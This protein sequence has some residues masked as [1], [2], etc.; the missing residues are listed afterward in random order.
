MKR[1]PKCNRTYADDAFTFCL[2][3]GA[4]LSAPYDPEKKEEPIST[5]QSGGPPPTAVLPAD[6]GRAETE[7]NRAAFPTIASPAVSAD[8]PEVKQF[9]PPEFQA[10]AAVSKKSKLPYVIISSLLLVFLLG[11]ISVIKLKTNQCPRV[12]VHCSSSPNSANCYLYESAK[13]RVEIGQPPV[14]KG[15]S[16]LS[17]TA[18]AGK[19]ERQGGGEIIIDTSGD[20]RRVIL[21]TARFSADGWFCSNTATG[22]FVAQ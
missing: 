6:S 9:V 22:L 13:P 11:G 16:N 15:V 10:S 21:V 17:W 18:S 3:D 20:P 7:T 19:I 1:C 2:E 5:I 4:L 14:P 8:A 12:N